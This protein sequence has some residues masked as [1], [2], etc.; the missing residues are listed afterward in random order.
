MLVHQTNIFPMTCCEILAYQ[1]RA[2]KEH[3]IVLQF[4]CVGCESY[5]YI[6]L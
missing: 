5:L 6:Y 2:F 1:T 4:S 3:D